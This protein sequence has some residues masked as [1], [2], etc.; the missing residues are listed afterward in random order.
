MKIRPFPPALLIA[1]CL[2]CN[3]ARAQRI[4]DPPR[5]A[6]TAKNDLLSYVDPFIG[7]GGHGHT[8][9]GATAPF[10]LVQL[11]P[12]TRIDM[13]DWDG[14][15]GYHYSDSLIYGF[16]H[17]HLSGTGVADYC[18]ILVM[19]YTGGA[20]LEPAEYASSFKKSKE[21]AE[22]GYY[23]VFLEKDR[24]KAELTATERVGVHRYNFPKNRL[25]G[26]LLVDLRHRDEVIRA[27]MKRVSDREIEGYRISKAWAREQHVY[28][29]MR[30]SRPFFN[31]RIL[32]MSINPHVANPAVH[33]ESIVGLLDFYEDGEPL[34]VTVGISGTSIEGARRNLEAE[35]DH[36]DFD[37]VKTE[38]QAKW[39]GQLSK[40]EVEGGTKAQKT[41]FY[42]AL[43]HTM[44]VPNVWSDADGQYRGRDNQVHPDPGHPVYTV[45]SLWDTYRACNPLYTLLEPARCNDFIKTFLR[46]YEQGG[47]LPVW[48]LAANE[49]DCMIGNHAIPVI[50]DAYL[51]GIRDYDAREALEA[52]QKSAGSDRYGLQWYRKLGYIPSDKEAES[53]SKTLEYA[54]DDWCIAQMAAA[55]HADSAG[56]AALE[57]SFSYLNLFDPDTRFFRAKNNAAWHKPFDPYEVNF[58]YTEANA[59]QYRFAVQQNIAGL[60]DI[61]G[62]SKAFG[63]QL[64]SLFQASTQTTGRDQADI[65]GLIGQYVHG[66][67]PSHHIAYLYNYAGQAWKTQQRVRQIMDEMYRAAPDGLSGNEDCGQMSAWFV[68]SAMGFYPVTPAC[69]DYIVGTPLF[70]K[71]TLHLDDGETFA[72]RAPGVSAERFYIKNM[73]LNGHR[74]AEGRINHAE[75]V[76][77]GEMVFDMSDSPADW[78]RAD[79]CQAGKQVEIIPVPF[80]AQGERVFEENQTVALACLDPGASIHY[81]LDGA[82]PDAKSPRFS[83]PF[84]IDHTLT[85]KAVAI[86]KAGKSPVAT[87]QFTRM[88]TGLSILRYNTQYSP[89]YT[90]RGEKGLVDG[91]H[92]GD[93]FRTGDWQGFQG[94][95]LDVVLDMGSL[96]EIN[97][98][99][100]GFMQDENAWIFFPLRVKV[101]FSE[102]GQTFSPAGTAENDVEA[103]EKG[104]L[105]KTFSIDL[106]GREA[107]YLRVV[108][109]TPGKCPEWH[110]GAGNPCW[111]FADEI[112]VK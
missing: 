23:S 111:I 4:A 103:S 95:D 55:M 48:E 38:T 54:F 110:K 74:R 51:K 94:V 42:T 20:K 35:C 44:V 16:S 22:A 71:V 5:Q 99:S 9:P 53:V 13:M 78:G 28:F 104:V 25:R 89:Q 19:P 93:D 105:Q 8:Y 43:Y 62:G 77:G 31:S 49:T 81:T 90:A 1:A 14:C 82:E 15:S 88:Q 79:A 39:G 60:M 50:A 30:F 64:D 7:T 61:M 108:G 112:T 65:T 21:H 96:R 58:N 12:D 76:K 47:L 84:R 3:I 32:D 56:H 27:H 6:N 46:Q 86:G 18:D 41:V 36:F 107:R 59:W 73:H 11:S 92:G 109:V 33:S 2:L 45:F 97:K 34:I 87:A 68:L 75:I 24:I 102:D 52:M 63:D 67:E 10:G 40:I 70:E 83:R 26:H 69:T 106:N 101:E 100:V 91:L 85:L 72:I 37:R 29:V 57:R 17:T 98:V 66:N 80:V